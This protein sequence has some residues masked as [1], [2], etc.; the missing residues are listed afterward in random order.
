MHTRC[1]YDGGYLSKRVESK[2]REGCVSKVETIEWLSLMC[3]I[4]CSNRLVLLSSS[5][6]IYAY[7]I[8]FRQILCISE[9]LHFVFRLCHTIRYDI[10][11]FNTVALACAKKQSERVISN[12]MILIF[13]YF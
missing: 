10:I 13:Y 6:Y 1:L 8:A 9:F 11:N 7:L 4:K 5:S 3:Y 2:I 12:L